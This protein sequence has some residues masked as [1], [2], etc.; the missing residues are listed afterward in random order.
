MQEL[1]IVEPKENKIEEEKR[2]EISKKNA[3]H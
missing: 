1:L 2:G 3:E